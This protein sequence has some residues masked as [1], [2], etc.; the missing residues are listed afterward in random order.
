[1]DYDNHES[2]PPDKNKTFILETAV[3]EVKSAGKS[4]KLRGQSEMEVSPNG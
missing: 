1:V 2:I 4:G 3:E